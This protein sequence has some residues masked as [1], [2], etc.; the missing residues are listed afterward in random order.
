MYEMKYYVFYSA[1]LLHYI[2]ETVLGLF[3]V[4]DG[5]ALSFSY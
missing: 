5:A 1:D 3:T 4:M 2:I